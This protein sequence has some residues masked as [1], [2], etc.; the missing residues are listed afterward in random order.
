MGEGIRYCQNCGSPLNANTRFCGQCGA[1]VNVND[2]GA[3]VPQPPPPPSQPPTPPPP[4]Y[5]PANPPQV[6]P[7]QAPPPMPPRIPPVE[8]KKKQSP[9]VIILFVGLIL[10]AGCCLL[11]IAG[12]YFGKQIFSQAMST[13]GI[14]SE[15]IGTGI[16]ESIISPTFAVQD[17]PVQ[18]PGTTLP[19]LES[20]PA[21]AFSPIQTAQPTLIPSP[22]V[23]E[24]SYENVTFLLDPSV[25]ED[26]LGETVP[27]E[28]PQGS[29]SFP[30]SVYPEHTMLSFS[31]YADDNTF[32][33]PQ[34]FIYPALKYEEYDTQAGETISQLRDILK[35]RNFSG[36]ESLPYLP[37]Y[38][39]AQMLHSNV[40]I[41][42]FK[43]G[44]GIR[45]L[46]MYGQDFGKVNNEMLV[47]TFQG[48]TTDNAY[49]VAAVLPVNHPDLPET[50]ELTPEEYSKYSDDF[51]AYTKEAVAELER[52]PDSSFTP[53]LEQLDALIRSLQIR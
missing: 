29:D 25:A 28:K 35:S 5:R 38:N 13:A 23:L 18:T 7:R 15:F 1:P 26:I 31:N 36:Y 2:L 52:K 37:I 8:G 49:Y 42:K 53:S 16:P 47:Y 3:S 24:F 6:Q 34:I 32:L 48:L 12:V 21:T 46:T 41:V 43:N 17:T 33:D 50:G 11:S 19:T 27:E 22:N 30:G 9:W 44:S 14:T 39:A 45:Y 40:K 20:T 4:P 10:L 51:S